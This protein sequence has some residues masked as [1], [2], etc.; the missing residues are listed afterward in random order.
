MALNMARAHNI[1]E[2]E[3]F[4]KANMWMGFQKAMASTHGVTEDTIK[5]ILNKD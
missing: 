5:V 1:S 3:T 2:M 4:I